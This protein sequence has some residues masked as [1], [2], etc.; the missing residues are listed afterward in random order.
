MKRALT[1]AA[2]VAA[3]TLTGCAGLHGTVTTLPTGEKSLTDAFGIIPA[4]RADVQNALAGAVANDDQVGIRCHAAALSWLNVVTTPHEVTVSGVAS[5]AESKRV[6]KIVLMAALPLLQDVE[7]KCSALY[8][9]RR[10]L[11]PMLNFIQEA[12]Q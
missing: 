1:L 5:L 10:A 12:T 8:P 7:D 9:F 2:I 6:K 3:L 11:G 4:L